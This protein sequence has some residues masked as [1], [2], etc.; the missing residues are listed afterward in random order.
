MNYF[1]FLLV[2][3]TVWSYSPK[4][5]PMKHGPLLIIDTSGSDFGSIPNIGYHEHTFTLRNDGDSMLHIS[6]IV[7]A[8]GCTAASL[9]D[10]LVPPGHSTDLL[11]RFEEKNHWPGGFSKEVAIVSNSRDMATKK[12]AFYGRFFAAPGSDTARTITFVRHFP[13]Q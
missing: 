1:T 8:C 7:P 2:V 5:D 3:L 12:F 11:I 4:N 9:K 6:A 10:S 13:K